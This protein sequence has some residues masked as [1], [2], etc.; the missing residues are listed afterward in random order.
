MTAVE[1]ATLTQF[2]QRLSYA[3]IFENTMAY[4]LTGEKRWVVGQGRPWPKLCCDGTY[5]YVLLPDGE[6]RFSDKPWPD[7]KMRHPEL[8]RGEEVIW[9]GIFIMKDGKVISISNESGHYAPNSD[10]LYFVRMAFKFWEAPLSES[11]VTDGRW[12]VFGNS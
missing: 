6:L 7:S 1:K 5:P 3:Q 12:E 4:Q 8:C 11:L 10:S 9:A 2:Q